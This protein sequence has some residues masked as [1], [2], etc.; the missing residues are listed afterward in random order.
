[1]NMRG[2]EMSTLQNGLG[3]QCRKSPQK[4][5]SCINQDG[6]QQKREDRTSLYSRSFALILSIFS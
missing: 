3:N 4:V 6:L 2:I 5:S 1:M